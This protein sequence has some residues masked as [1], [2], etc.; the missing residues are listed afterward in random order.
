MNNIFV[1]DN[2]GNLSD[3]LKTVLSESNKVFTLPDTE[4]LI[5]LTDRIKPSVILIFADTENTHSGTIKSIKGCSALTAVPI[6]VIAE[7]FTEQ[8]AEEIFETGADDI[9][10]VPFLISAVKKRIE[11][12]FDTGKKITESQNSLRNI[13]NQ[14]IS[15]IAELVEDRDKITGGHIERTQQY[16]KILIDGLIKS[17]VY[18]DAISDW[19]LNLLLPSAQLH[20]VGKITISDLILNKPGKLT[21]DEFAV[22]KSHAPEGERIINEIMAK[23]DDDGFLMHAKKFAGFHHEKWDGSGYPRGLRGEE[24]PLEGRIMAIADVYDALVSARPYKKPFTHEQAIE[25]ITKDSG[26]HFDPEIVKV[27]KEIADDFWV[28]SF[29][30]NSETTSQN[31]PITKPTDNPTPQPKKS[32]LPAIEKPTE[33]VA[34]IKGIVGEFAGTQIEIISKTLFGRGKIC[35]IIYSGNTRGISSIHCAIEISEG[36]ILLSDKNSTFGTFV[37]GKKI[38]PN[39]NV[40][41]V[42][43]DEIWL[44][45]NEETFLVI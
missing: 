14:L 5:K 7:G 4:K 19:D 26:T 18:S 38:S 8:N 15:V 34:F 16:L 31:S 36:N 23:T 28:Q 37:N 41:L 3:S 40:K 20:D 42:R 43:G 25:I 22:I 32:E 12:F 24:I 45:S 13:Q 39:R 29:L 35:N 17:G 21:D 33:T 10:T 30:E 44:G 9:I 11:S 2:G 6:V 1:I 27:F